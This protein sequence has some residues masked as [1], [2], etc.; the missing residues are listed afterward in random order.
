MDY[1][2]DEEEAEAFCKFHMRALAQK[3]PFLRSIVENEFMPDNP[4]HELI[5][6]ESQILARV[7]TDTDELVDRVYDEIALM[8]NGVIGESL[9]WALS[10][11]RRSD[12][13]TLELMTY[14]INQEMDKGGVLFEPGGSVMFLENFTTDEHR[15]DCDLSTFVYISIMHELGLA[16]SAVFAPNHVYAHSIDDESHEERNIEVQNVTY[17][18]E[19][20]YIWD[21][22]ERRQ[23]R[24]DPRIDQT[25]IDAHAYLQS[26]TQTQFEGLYLFNIANHISKEASTIP[27]DTSDAI[28]I[29]RESLRRF[30]D[31]PMALTGLALNELELNEAEAAAGHLARAIELDPNLH[32]AYEEIAIATI[33]MAQASQNEEEQE[34]LYQ[35]ALE[36]LNSA[37][38]LQ[39]TSSA[40][41]NRGY[42]YMALWRLG[43]DNSFS[44]HAEDDFRRA[45]RLDPANETANQNM[46]S[47]DPDRRH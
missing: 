45:I 15:F 5:L 3:I 38:N 28:D 41:T 32:A 6:F 1:Y 7:R 24:G 22:R 47:V 34:S 35:H 9:K 31:N 25:S 33:N 23:R 26:L 40:Y 11:G 14:W 8:R 4:I 39:P 36:Y 30:P 19:D 21:E 18:D 43:G 29:Y 12:W 20:F 46:Q 16:A 42:I 17:H 2:V 27:M 37:I 44:R 13:S 10:G